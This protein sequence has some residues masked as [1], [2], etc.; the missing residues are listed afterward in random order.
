MHTFFSQR[1]D[2][3]TNKATNTVGG[4][5]DGPFRREFLQFVQPDALF[6]TLEGLIRP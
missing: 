4:K 3:M 5:R 1:E 6:E 2:D